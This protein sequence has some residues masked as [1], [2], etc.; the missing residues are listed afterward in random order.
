M[1]LR[2]VRAFVAGAEAGSIRGAARLLGLTQPAV[3]KAVQQLEAELAA[4]LI[5]RNVTGVTLTSYGTAF[6]ARA[7]LV[8]AE[9][10]RAREEIAQMADSFGGTVS[11]GVAPTIAEL[12][13][14]RVVAAF[15][16]RRPQV[17]VRLTGGLPTSTIDR[18]CDGTLDFAVGPRPVDGVPA[19]VDAWHLYSVDVAIT[20]R[21]GHPLVRAR[22]LAAFADAH[23]VLTRSAANADGP[24]TAAFARL[25]LPPPHC[26][27]QS[28]SFVAA[29]ALVAQTDCVSLMPCGGVQLGAMRRQL[30][31]IRVPEL[32]IRNS[33]ELFFRRDT[34]LT[35]AA[36]ELASAF[37]DA[38]RAQGLG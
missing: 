7:R 37:R 5:L 20:V 17:M 32:E 36:L 10:G 21:R 31:I 18:V 38:A 8:A 9:L 16:A 33:I 4:P 25:G 3:T 15:Q 22:S 11:L 24:L 30:T 28:E 2:H 1:N 14:P 23:W 13:A 26:R 35:P 29:Q 19:I 34:P 12:I 6:L 27:L